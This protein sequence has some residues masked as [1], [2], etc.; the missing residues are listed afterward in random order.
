MHYCTC[1][2]YFKSALLAAVIAMNRVNNKYTT[3]QTLALFYVPQLF[4][5]HPLYFGRIRYLSTT[6]AKS[7]VN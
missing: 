2:R 6:T 3:I 5:L 7:Q 1:T 4:L